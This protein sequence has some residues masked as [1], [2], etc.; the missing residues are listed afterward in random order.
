M[1]AFA[2]ASNSITFNGTNQRLTSGDVING[3]SGT[4]QGSFSLLFRSLPSHPTNNLTTPRYVFCQRGNITNELGLF[5]EPTNAT[6]DSGS[7]KLQIGGQTNILL[8]SNAIVL[9]TWYY[10]AMTWNES[11]NLATW[12]L[13]PI[14]GTLN[15]SNINFGAT[16]AVGNS[17]NVVFGNRQGAPGNNNSASNYPNAFAFLPATEPWA[18]SPSGTGN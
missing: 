7:L 2:T 15:T 12:Y 11:S 13:A 10:L 14:G 9:G 16:N 18:K 17:T 8:A 1:D 4:N 6:P 3:G 5:F